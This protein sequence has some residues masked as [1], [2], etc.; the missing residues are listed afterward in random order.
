MRAPRRLGLPER[1]LRQLAR[2]QATILKY[3]EFRFRPQVRVEDAVRPPTQRRG[4]AART[5]PASRR[6]RPRCAPAGEDDLRQRIEA[7]V[8][9]LRGGADVRY[10]AAPSPPASADGS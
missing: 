4:A 7:W 3:V 2:R 8:K 1:D 5:R 9:E 10:N 6:P